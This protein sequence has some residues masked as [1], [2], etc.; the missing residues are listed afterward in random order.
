MVE[1]QAHCDIGEVAALSR[2]RDA[3]LMPT[4]KG[5]GPESGD[6]PAG[7]PLVAITFR[8]AS[9]DE[10]LEVHADGRRVDRAA[11][12]EQTRELDAERMGAIRAALAET[13][14]AAL[15]SRLC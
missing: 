6:P 11:G 12:S 4:A 7:T 10:Q 8:A 15:P 2:L 14:W 5:S 9:G 1:L 13:D 3:L